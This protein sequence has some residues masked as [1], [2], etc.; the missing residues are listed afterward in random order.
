[1][2]ELTL[3]TLR[4][5]VLCFPHVFVFL[6]SLRFSPLFSLVAGSKD[7]LTSASI[8]LDRPVAVSVVGSIAASIIPHLIVH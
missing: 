6:L 2:I 7:S 8:I 3:S 5:H 4:P 1:M